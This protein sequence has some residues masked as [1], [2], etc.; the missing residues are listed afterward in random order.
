MF[1]F[2]KAKIISLQTWVNF[3]KRQEILRFLDKDITKIFRSEILLCHIDTLTRWIELKLARKLSPEV[4][5]APSLSALPD[6][7]ADLIKELYTL[8]RCTAYRFRVCSFISSKQRV[9]WLAEKQRLTA[10]TKIITY[11]NF[12]TQRECSTRPNRRS[13][14]GAIY[15]QS[16]YGRMARITKNASSCC[17]VSAN[18]VRMLHCTAYI[19][20]LV[21]AAPHRTTS[22][23]HF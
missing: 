17:A 5:F 3:R 16:L 22:Y 2:W 20:I 14:Q 12:R 1:F 10:C 9:S 8:N 18:L 13:D 4:T 23:L 7:V 15:S 6:Q 19:H 11:G 21:H